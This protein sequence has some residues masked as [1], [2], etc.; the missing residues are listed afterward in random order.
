MNEIKADK[1]SFKKKLMR[2]LV[3]ILN[4]SYFS[5]TNRGLAHI[6]KLNTCS[7]K[8]VLEHRLK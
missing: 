6:Q 7:L 2:P 4:K 8:R 3:S 1:K 5:L